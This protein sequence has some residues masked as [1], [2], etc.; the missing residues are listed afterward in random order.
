M[1]KGEG[2][3]SETRKVVC[4]KGMTKLDTT[5]FYKGHVCVHVCVLC[6]LRVFFN[7]CLL[8]WIIYRAVALCTCR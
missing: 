4:E 7:Y 2:W 1:N 3:E 5:G 8:V 6:A